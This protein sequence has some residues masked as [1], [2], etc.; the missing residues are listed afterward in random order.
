MQFNNNPNQIF[1]MATQAHQKGQLIQAENLYR[2][3]L[4][5]IPDHPDAL[6]LLGLVCSQQGK[7]Y[8]AVQFIQK[9]TFLN[10]QNPVFLNNLAEALNRKG[11]DILAINSF[12]QALKIAPDFA[13]AH[14]NLAN[15]LKKLNK[16]EDA[17]WHYEQAIKFNPKHVSSYYNLGNLLREQGMFRSAM[18][19]YKKAVELNPNYVEAHNNLGATYR[20]FDETD[21]ALEQ[22]QIAYKLNPGSIEPVRNIMLVLE[23]QGKIEEAKQL[24][25]QMLEA[26]PDNLPLRVHYEGMFNQIPFSNQQIDEYRNHLS[27]ELEKYFDSNLH[28][29]WAKIHEHGGEPCSSTV[30]HGRD[31]KEIK[32]KYAKIYNKFIPHI[33][34]PSNNGKPHIGFVV[35]NGHE[36]VFIKCMRGILNNLPTEK[37]DITVVS[38]R[39]NGEKIIRPVITNPAIR[40]LNFSQIFTEAVNEILAARFDLLFYWEVGTDA[41][42]YFLP[43]CRLAPVQCACLG[44]PLTTGIPNVDY[45][46]SSELLEPEN[47]EEHYTETLIKLKRLPFYYYRP[48]VPELIKPK[49][50]FAVNENQKIYLCAQNLRKLQPDFDNLAS[51][52]LKKDKN[53]I[54][55]LV[56]DKQK[57]IT[58]LLKNRLQTTVPDV[59]DRIRV[60]PRMEEI[61][62]L[63][64]VKNADVILDSVH[65]TGGANT[66]YD[67]FAAGTPIVT[68]PGKYHRGRYT[69]A[70]YKQMGI[71]DCISKDNEHYSELAVNIANNPELRQN[72][73][74]KILQ[75]CH[76]LF[77]DKAAVNQLSDFFEEKIF[78]QRTGF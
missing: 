4:Q 29:N 18:E 50:A 47:G 30:Y 64:L 38:N 77:E 35:T 49:S 56:E 62:Y 34:L 28:I 57:N 7:H 78:A 60:L 70:A 33:E 1:M 39:P 20:L 48:P 76:H 15:V 41:L 59:I 46:V 21:E 43:F 40:F 65:Y 63:S 31:D 42:N 45:F 37:F 24:Y 74:N 22:Y 58:Q 51:S 52:I 3:V 2:Q 72:I 67:A 61:D 27:K 5:K 75:N 32:A 53:G 66:S 11:D 6:H 71:D 26:E 54:L 16:I 36:G 17:K 55:L 10:P 9:A 23:M 12:H 8:D 25:P 69:Y 68:L 19:N 13:E 14:F 73:S 44:W